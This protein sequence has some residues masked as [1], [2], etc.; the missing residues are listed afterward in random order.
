MGKWFY[1]YG[2]PTCIHCDQSQ[3]FENEILEHLYTSYGVKQLTAMD[4][5]HIKMPPVRGLTM[6]TMIYQ[7]IGQ[8]AKTKL[9]FVFII[10]CV[11][12]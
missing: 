10:F 9:A 2:I 12:L 8:G 4:T 11:S 1:I 7:N 3:S 6:C 5:T